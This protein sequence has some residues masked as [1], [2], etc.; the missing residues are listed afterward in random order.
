MQ[1]QKNSTFAL[2]IKQWAVGPKNR[3]KAYQYSITVLVMLTLDY[4]L[5]RT[6]TKVAGYILESLKLILLSNLVSNGAF[7]TLSIDG[8][9]PAHVPRNTL[10]TSNAIT[11]I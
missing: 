11:I 8:A 4:H 5:L 6:L 9:Q 1:S 2:V 10:S 3:T 7:S